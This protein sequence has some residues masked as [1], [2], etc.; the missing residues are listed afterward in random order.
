MRRFV[1]F[2]L[3]LAVTIPSLHADIR[4]WES[5]WQAFRAAYPYHIQVIALSK[6]NSAGAR[7]LI[8][9]EPPPGFT[10]DQIAK[11]APESFGEMVLPRQRI[12]YDGWV[13]DAAIE[14]KPLS[15]RQLAALIDTLHTK[16]FGTAYKAIAVSIPSSRRT[17]NRDYN[18]DLHVSAG[19]IK[20]WLLPDLSMRLRRW[21][22]LLVVV[23][24]ALYGMR[25]LTSNRRKLHALALLLAAIAAFP[26]YKSFD[27]YARASREAVLFKSPFS[28]EPA[29]ATTLLSTRTRG[30]FYSDPAGLVLWIFPKDELLNS[31][32]LEA[33]RF[34]LDS[35]I[36][37][38][39][40]GDSASVAV[41]AR[42]RLAPIDVL[43]PLRTETILQL[44]SVK[45][46]ELSQSY[47]RLHVL[48]GKFDGVHDWAP[49]YLSDELIDTEY[50]S[51]LNIT[52]QLLK[53]WSSAGKVRYVN[54]RYPDPEH[55]P[56]PKPLI[57]YAN[58]DV[59]TFN[60]NTKGAGYSSQFGPFDVFA[61]TRTGALPVDYLGNHDARLHAA[62]DT[63]YE[64]FATRSDP[65]L[66]RVVQYAEL[67][68]IFRHYG[69]SAST[70]PLTYH[71]TTPEVFSTQIRSLLEN[72]ST[73]SDARIETRSRGVDLRQART[74]RDAVNK[75][76]QF[77]GTVLDNLVSAL[78]A[79]RAY[80]KHLVEAGNT[81]RQSLEW[82]VAALAGNCQDTLNLWND[83]APMQLTEILQA[84]VAASD[85]PSRGWIHTPSIVISQPFGEVANTTGGH[86]LDSTATLLRPSSELSAGQVKVVEENGQRILEYSPED[87]NRIQQSVRPVAREEDTS[88]AN[89]ESKARASLAEAKPDTRPLPDSLNFTAAHHPS[90]GRGFQPEH[91]PAYAEKAGWWLPNENPSGPQVR[92]AEA[93]NSSTRHTIVVE[94]SGNDGYTIFDGPRHQILHASTKPGTVDAVFALL[95]NQ[96]AAAA[97]IHLHFRGFDPREAK[98]FVQT[99]E[100][101]SEGAAHR[102]EFTASVEDAEFDPD[103]LKAFLQEHYNFHEVEIQ[104]VSQ[105]F[106]T[107]QG[108]T[109]IDVDAKIAAVDTAK[110]PL[111][112]RIRIILKA[113]FEMTADLLVSIKQAISNILAVRAAASDE[114]VL[115][116]ATFVKVLEKIDSRI[117]Y[118]HVKVTDHG[119]KLYLALDR[120]PGKQTVF[121]G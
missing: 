17:V 90:P 83:L 120:K 21:E 121:A 82:R 72:F 42:E 45:D 6:P 31:A 29:L 117:D 102:V 60:W 89:L 26:A 41:V 20:R 48:A 47:E 18:L 101:Q 64:Y 24:L 107:P 44:A 53:S 96:P 56:F 30:V 69:V 79:P 97:K 109:G 12:G 43:P 119:K 81:N 8:I 55:F 34:A 13:R 4:S 63:G 39:S 36:V 32:R 27:R 104:N 5:E 49:I 91:A 62:E 115:A 52:D 22:L 93:L 70:S 1:F 67:Y 88:A 65:N 84:Y 54:F 106:V 9:S 110:P 108:Q 73:L 86:N 59:V 7:L 74:C 112:V 57:V 94:R 16:I 25:L 14:L 80:R 58:A 66:A 114:S 98:G 78:A 15:E 33:R 11:L 76:D 85:R 99:A 113:G 111:L 75:V 100:L 46:S 19:T 118:V 116:T 92:L 51:L 50:G 61:W 105:P 10:A 28:N 2:T 3:L 37:L 103:D 35:D 87:A 40:V 38:G 71:P 23:L 68:Q 77:G 95:D